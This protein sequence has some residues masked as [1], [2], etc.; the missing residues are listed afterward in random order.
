[1]PSKRG[2]AIPAAFVARRALGPHLIQSTGG[3]STAASLE[4]EQAVAGERLW[5]LRGRPERTRQVYLCTQGTDGT[6]ECRK[7]S[8][9]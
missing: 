3:Q 1:M 6:P 9:P 4:Q 5:I 8:L 7:T 2:V